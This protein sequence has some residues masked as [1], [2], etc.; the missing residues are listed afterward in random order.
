MGGDGSVGCSQQE[1]CDNSL[2]NG[3]LRGGRSPEEGTRLHPGDGGWGSMGSGCEEVTP[4][5]SLAGQIGVD[6]VE[7]MGERN[8]WQ[9]K[10]TQ[11]WD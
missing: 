4:E 1:V 6:Q 2:E 5:L 10:Q 11:I 3:F 9:R 7:V 8:F